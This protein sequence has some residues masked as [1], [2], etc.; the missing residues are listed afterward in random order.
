MGGILDPDGA[1]ER[2]AAWKGGIDRLAADTKLTAGVTR[3]YN[4]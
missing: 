2:L 4:Q 3:A 1:M